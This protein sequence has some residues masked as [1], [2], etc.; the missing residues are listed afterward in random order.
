MRQK[1]RFTW[2]AVALILTVALVRVEAAGA[3]D[4][5]RWA[6]GL[7]GGTIGLGGELAWGVAEWCTMRLSAHRGFFEHE[8]RIRDV[9][10]GVELDFANASLLAD[11][12]APEASFRLT[13]GVVHSAD[14]WSGRAQP[15]RPTRIG[16]FTFLPEEIGTIRA[17]AEVPSSA[18]YLGVGFGNPFVGRRWTVT[19]DLGVWFFVDRPDVRLSSDGTAA[20]IWLFDEALER[21]ERELADHLPRWWP[22]VMLG[23]SYRFG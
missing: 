2:C 9:H 8:E 15:A 16:G 4:L 5:H 21:E 14:E 19:L 3:M 12:H 18:A 6:A 11:L 10:Y 23:I 17:E 13:V 20:G 7:R 22:V 1:H